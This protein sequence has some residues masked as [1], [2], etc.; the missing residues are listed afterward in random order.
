VFNLL[1]AKYILLRL[2]IRTAMLEILLGLTMI[3]DICYYLLL[4]STLFQE[5]IA[6]TCF[7]FYRNLVNKLCKS[8][9]RKYFNTGLNNTQSSSHNWWNEIK[10]LSGTSKNKITHSYHAPK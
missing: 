7:K 9:K 2:V 3:H 5:G 6:V 1:T 4:L 8:A 10:D